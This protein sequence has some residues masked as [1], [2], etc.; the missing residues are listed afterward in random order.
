MCEAQ[1]LDS[2]CHGNTFTTVSQSLA[3]ADA[4]LDD[5]ARD[6]DSCKSARCELREIN[7]G[8]AL[9]MNSLV[10]AAENDTVRLTWSS[11][12]LDDGSGTPTTYEIWRRPL[13]SNDPFVKIGTVKALTF[14]DRDTGTAP[15][16]YEIT[17]VI[18]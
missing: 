3:D 1:S 4:V 5:P 8:H 9:E 7:N 2:K 13:G 15:W 18:P 16:E 11:P 12:V 10:V 6:R 14:L 17:A